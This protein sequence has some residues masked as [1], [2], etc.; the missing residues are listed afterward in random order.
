[1][2]NRVKR[3]NMK[4]KVAQAHRNLDNVMSDIK[5]LYDLFEPVHP[6]IAEGLEISAELC[7]QSQM[8]L[9]VF[10]ERAW[11]MDKASLNAFL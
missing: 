2:T 9:E 4:R 3:D 7:L 6:D 10:I 1:M 8:L 5:T 11:S